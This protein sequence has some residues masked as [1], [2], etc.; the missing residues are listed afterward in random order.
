MLA[1]QT[2]PRITVIIPAYNLAPYINDCLASIEAQTLPDWECLV[3]DDG[4]TDAT[5]PQVEAR[6][7][8]R[9]R[10]LRQRNA[11][12]STARNAGLAEAR[13]EF[14]MFLD[15]D[16]KLHPAALAR[17]A[18]ALTSEPEPVAAFGTL[19]KVLDN[20]DPYPGQKPLAQH[21]YPTGDVLGPMIEENF[22][23]NGGHVLVRTAAA[24]AIGGFNP[25]LRLSEDWEFWCRLAAQGPFTFIGTTPEIFYLR[26]RFG[27]SLG[28]ATDWANHRASIDAVLNNPTLQARFAPAAWASLARRVRA[29]HMWEA[30]R[31]NFT[32]R[33]FVP[34][35]RLMLGSLRIHPRPKRIALF[36]LALLSQA[37]NRPLASRLRFIDQDRAAG[38]A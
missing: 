26:M 25:T 12:V 6:P 15:G 3:V 37:L 8:P 38:N 9:I 18:A 16:D 11:G 31:V 33:R 5:A 20:G 13:G 36:G 35:C 27:T 17:L 29:S 1:D 34:A 28:L 24:R 30:G 23:A 21:Q 10:L 32:S 7:D 2:N 14:T 22:L 4:S 19:L